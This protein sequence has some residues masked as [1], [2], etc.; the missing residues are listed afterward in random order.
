[1]QQ[2][3][4]EEVA[5]RF[6]NTLRGELGLPEFILENAR[7]EKPLLVKDL[8]D[9]PS[10]WLVPVAY[11]ERLVGFFRIGLEGELL[12]Y[13]RFGQGQE[14]ESFHPLSYLN[15]DQVKKEMLKA[16]GGLYDEISSPQL[17]HDGPPDR[18]AWLAIGRRRNIPD[19]MLFWALGYS[20]TRPEGQK[21]EYGML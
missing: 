7:Y 1:L 11:K 14:I 10:Y 4:I 3:E 5:A 16:F 20:Y 9:N 8:D 18:I 21:P 2:D 12:A 13:G 19:E 15:E 6:F 17:V